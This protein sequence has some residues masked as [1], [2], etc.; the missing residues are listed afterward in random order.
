[1]NFLEKFFSVKNKFINNGKEKVVRIFGR[2]ILSF[3][4]FN[5]MEGIIEY[6]NMPFTENFEKDSSVHP[7]LV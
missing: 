1:M 4:L 3:K 7:K 2:E 5:L 6:D